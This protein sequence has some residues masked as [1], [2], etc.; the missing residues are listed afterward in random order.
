MALASTALAVPSPIAHVRGTS[1]P[2][3]ATQAPARSAQHAPTS[4][5]RKLIAAVAV[6]NIANDACWTFSRSI[7]LSKVRQ[8]AELVGEYLTLASSITKRFSRAQS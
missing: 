3:Y 1:G 5:L 2:L 8:S 4:G 7:S 6:L